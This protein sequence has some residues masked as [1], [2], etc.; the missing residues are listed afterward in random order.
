M[1][2]ARREL[3]GTLLE[4][5]LALAPGDRAAFL[6]RACGS[7]TALYDEVMALITTLD[8]SPDYLLDLAAHIAPVLDGIGVAGDALVGATIDHYEVVERIGVGGMGVVYRA[9]DL[10]LDRNVALKFL[11]AALTTDTSARM[12]L[13]AEA[14]AVSTLDHPNIGVVHE[15][16]E[17]HTGGLFIAMAWYEGETLKARL[18]HGALETSDALA[19]AAQIASALTAAHAAGIIHRDV[20][21]SNVLLGTGGTARLLDFGIAKVA[22]AE[23]TREGTTLGTVAYMS[24]EQTHGEEVDART[25]VWSL[26][27]VL[28]E[29]LAGRRPFRGSTDSLLLH[30]IRHDEHEPLH[31][32]R[33]DLSA[34]IVQ[35]VDGCL[36]KPRELRF[37]SAAAVTRA[38]QSAAADNIAA[39]ATRGARRWRR[40]AQA[41]AA[42]VSAALLYSGY[43]YST[44]MPADAREEQ[45]VVV[46]R[47]ENHTGLTALDAVGTIA[48]DWVIQALAQ[49][50]LV[51]VVPIS[52]ALSA[53][54]FALQGTSEADSGRRVSLLAEETGAD[55]VI[56]GAYQQQGDSLYIWAR[57]TDVAQNRVLFA[58]EP[59][60][61]PVTQPLAA[62]QRLRERLLSGLAPHLDP[63]LGEWTVTRPGA[64]VPP[65]EAY[66]AFAEGLDR[67]IA[68]DWRGAVD[69]FANADRDDA[70][71][72]PPLFFAGI[73]FVN[74]GDMAAL[75]SV[76][77]RAQPHLR[78]LSEHERLGFEF[79]A[80]LLRG[81]FVA[82]HRSQLR[83]PEFA[84]GGL[85][86]WGLA[87]A[88]MWVNRPRETIRVSRQLDPERGELRGWF[89]YF[90]DLARAHHR[91]GQHREELRV[92]RRARAL[93]PHEPEAL[94][95]EV[96]ALAALRR[97]RDLIA[98]LDDHLHAH[99]APPALLRQAAL[100]LY[101]HNQSREA[102]ALVRQGLA[103]RLERPNNT[104]GFRIYVAEAHI[105]LDG[106]EDG[107]TMIE[108]LAADMPHVLDAQGLLGTLA[109]RRGERDRAAAISDNLADLPQREHRGRNTYWRARIAALLGDRDEAVRLLRQAFSE[110]TEVWNTLHLEPDFDGLRDFPAFRAFAR[111]RG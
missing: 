87:N 46:G 36:Q 83:N 89:F 14:R 84:P 55:I 47:F 45:R 30:G 61:T 70:S 98:F 92:A 35:V 106:I 74:M 78:S 73:A 102:E 59:F 3:L 27:V 58:L 20:K 42:V 108:A 13:M 39:P 97:H 60:S 69:H 94:L 29:M 85:G 18:Q 15:I 6:D 33:P 2:D 22:G 10:R 79:L 7:D 109:A 52:A 34:E 38:L 66:R 91:L 37:E 90:R 81:D 107:A 80:A 5:A 68:R 40:R 72:L 77:R 9:R 28:Y 103:L 82:A 17:S 21:P 43:L 41:A 16:G 64:D 26:G 48:A 110:G 50:G 44:R 65:Y 105:L 62:M 31:A 53:S 111:P 23:L 88:A 12:R 4:Q 86:H 63:R 104:I 19:V 49:S 1:D 71:F 100:E 56:S 93:F 99:P 95:L 101:G 25:D 57:A 24:P 11:P 76:L 67:F 75:D 96:R 54:R 51:Q 32:L 8:S